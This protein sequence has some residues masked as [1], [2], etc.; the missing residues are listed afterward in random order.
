MDN[1]YVK[2]SDDLHHMKQLFSFSFKYQRAFI[3]YAS[4]ICESYSFKKKQKFSKMY[5]G[6]DV[7]DKISSSL[8]YCNE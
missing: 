4:V 3:M 2:M 5:T 6:R 1:S 7:C 8:A